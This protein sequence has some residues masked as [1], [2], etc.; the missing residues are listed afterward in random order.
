LTALSLS[1]CQNK[2]SAEID[3]IIKMKNE[4]EY[5]N[6][7]PFLDWITKNSFTRNGEQINIQVKEID[8]IENCNVGIFDIKKNPSS[9]SL[10]S[11][12]AGSVDSNLEYAILESFAEIIDWLKSNVQLDIESQTFESVSKA[13]LRNY[14]IEYKKTHTE[15]NSSSELISSISIFN[16]D[17]VYITYLKKIEINLDNNTTEVNLIKTGNLDARSFLK[18][19]LE[20]AVSKEPKFAILIYFDSKNHLYWTHL[21]IALS[22]NAPQK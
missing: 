9:G 12:S 20:D 6:S 21:K 22:D 14:D 4:R 7:K 10:V 2:K 13:K 16:K 18:D 3:P 1:C 19:M 17:K 5:E 8:H 15:S 11:L